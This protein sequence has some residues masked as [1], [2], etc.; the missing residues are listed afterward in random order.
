MGTEPAEKEKKKSEK[1]KRME[2]GGKDRRRKRLLALNAYGARKALET[3][4][5]KG[6]VTY[7]EKRES[8]DLGHT[9]QLK[10]RI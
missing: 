8:E 3:S 2:N 9:E 6:I 10:Y 1:N 7:M 4:E 5:R